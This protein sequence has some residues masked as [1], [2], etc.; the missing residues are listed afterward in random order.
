LPGRGRK[1]GKEEL[2]RSSLPVAW[3]RKEGW[4]GELIRS[5]LPVAWKRKEGWQGGIDYIL[6]ACCLE[7]E[8]RMARRN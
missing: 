1:D 3:E 2:I 5:S 7:Q 6:T 8:G 4:Q